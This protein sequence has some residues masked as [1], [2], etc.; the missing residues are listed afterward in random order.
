[1]ARGVKPRLMIWRSLVWSGASWLTIITF[2]SST[3]SR[4][5]SS[6]NRMMTPF[7]PLAKS[8]EFFEMSEMSAWR[9]IAQ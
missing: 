7:W 5:M 6:A 9:V 1:M 2:C 3:W 8:L 4:V